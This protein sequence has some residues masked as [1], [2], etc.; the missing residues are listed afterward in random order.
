MGA[1]TTKLR[2]DY[3][4]STR[5][6]RK[7]QVWMT[8][9]MLD[10]ALKPLVK[11][12]STHAFSPC[13]HFRGPKTPLYS[14]V[15]I[16][17]EERDALRFHW[18][19]SEHSEVDTLRFPRALYGLVLAPFLRGGVNSEFWEARVQDHVDKFLFYVNDLIGGN[20]L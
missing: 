14:R 1:K 9:C 2:I 10:P 18:K 5:P 13:R 12:V 3:D 4:A 16:K 6:I 11:C 17:K 19:T 15:R 7:Y 20:Q 8:V